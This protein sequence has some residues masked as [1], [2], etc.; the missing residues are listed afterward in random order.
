MISSYIRETSYLAC[1]SIIDLP[2]SVSESPCW[3]ELGGLA[4]QANLLAD[5]DSKL[6]SLIYQ[7]C[8]LGFPV[9][10]AVG[11]R[12]PACVSLCHNCLNFVWRGS[13]IRICVLLPGAVPEETI[14]S[15]LIC[16][17]LCFWVFSAPL[18]QSTTLSHFNIIVLKFTQLDSCSFV[19]FIWLF[20]YNPCEHTLS[21]IYYLEKYLRFF[22]L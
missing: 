19:L 4:P 8:F 17:I 12:D 20:Y 21:C 1:A 10:E 6:Q 7:M 11:L 18:Q 13:D 5:G 22:L 16:I 3:R 9:S 15:I 2:N 14:I